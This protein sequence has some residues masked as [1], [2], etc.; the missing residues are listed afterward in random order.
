MEWYVLP[1]CSSL[2]IIWYLFAHPFLHI[3]ILLLAFRVSHRIVCLD[4]LFCHSACTNTC[5]RLH[6]QYVFGWGYDVSTVIGDHRW[7]VVS[8]ALYRS[9]VLPK[10]TQHIQKISCIDPTPGE[11]IVEAHVPGHYRF[12]G[13]VYEVTPVLRLPNIVGFVAV[14]VI[15][16]LADR[17]GDNRRNFIILG[18]FLMIASSSLW[19]FET[20]V[21]ETHIDTCEIHVRS[22]FQGNGVWFYQTFDRLIA[23]S[24]AIS[25]CQGLLW[26]LNPFVYNTGEIP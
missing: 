21:S 20:A 26:I 18:V 3:F 12:A 5:F 8:D 24:L 7:K 10:G 13:V 4:P 9:R 23:G 2:K 15:H 16:V 6:R 19:L 25:L 14:L 1:W 22:I 17:L 11:A